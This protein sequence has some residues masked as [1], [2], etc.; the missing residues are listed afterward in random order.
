MAEY[1]ACTAAVY[2][3]LFCTFHKDMDS[4]PINEDHLPI[5]E[6]QQRLSYFHFDYFLKKH[7][8]IGVITTF[9]NYKNGVALS[10]IEQPVMIWGG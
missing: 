8:G 10:A 9:F 1:P 2:Q 4:I 7:L 5:N 6:F 3:P